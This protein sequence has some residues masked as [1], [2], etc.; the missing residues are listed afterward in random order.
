MNKLA[1]HLQDPSVLSQGRIVIL[2]WMDGALEGFVEFHDVAGIWYFKMIGQRYAPED[3]DSRLYLLGLVDHAAFEAME[4]RL[5][6]EDRSQR[7]SPF[8]TPHWTG[9]RESHYTAQT[10]E[11]IDLLISAAQPEFIALA[12]SLSRIESLWATNSQYFAHMKT[13]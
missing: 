7:D 10:L 12:R 9:L 8:R 2:D 6:D 5:P 4:A 3:L 11:M 13:G 1:D